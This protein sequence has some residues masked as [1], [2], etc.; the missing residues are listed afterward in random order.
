MATG[1][2]TSDDS[3]HKSVRSMIRFMRVRCFARQT[4]DLPENPG[5]DR[6]FVIQSAGK[7]SNLRFPT[8]N[9]QIPLGVARQESPQIPTVANSDLPSLIHLV[10]MRAVL[11]EGGL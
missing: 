1:E 7:P 6:H 3:G 4:A 2:R 9:A 10:A 8:T 5:R 11:G